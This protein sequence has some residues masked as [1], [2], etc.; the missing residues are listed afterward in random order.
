[1]KTISIFSSVLF[2]V[3]FSCKPAVDFT[4]EIR[5]TDS[6]KTELVNATTGF[7]SL[8]SNKLNDAGVRI[9]SYFSFINS[10]L[11]DTITKEEALLL[12]NLKNISKVV[13]KYM[14][15]KKDLK[16]H[17][18]FNVKQLENLAYDLQNKSIASKDSAK[19]FIMDEVIANGDLI[20]MMKMHMEKIPPKLKQYD[21][22]MVPAE[23]FIR[24]I[25]NGTIPPDLIKPSQVPT[26][27]EE[28]D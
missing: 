12:S 10:N 18:N 3:L 20:H 9:N 26:E 23:A 1:M 22:L 28:D 8:D 27:V 14:K 11:K 6:L 5:K 4:D 19:K 21:S 7:Y 16:L 15:T 17:Y 25:N 24:K 2:L 13:G